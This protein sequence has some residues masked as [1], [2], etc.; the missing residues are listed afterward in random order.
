[1]REIGAVFAGEMS[2]H[3][4]FADE[5]YGFDD[6]LYAA[7]RLLRILSRQTQPLSALLAD[8]PR[9]PITPEVRVTCPDDRKFEV[10]AALVEAFKRTHEV[11]DID[12]ARVLFDDGWG[13]IRASNTQPVLVVRA[14]AQ[15]PEALARIKGTLAD[16]L[17]Q[18]PEVGR[19]EW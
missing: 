18:F 2:G 14:E 8:V 13:L 17:A 1:M 16:A 12:G 19:P 11:V 15:T 9:Y 3:M 5:Y 6:A 10:V 7:G 4:F